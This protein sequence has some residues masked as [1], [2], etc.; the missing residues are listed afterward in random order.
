MDTFLGPSRFS[1]DPP[2]APGMEK[3]LARH[4]CQVVGL[5][6]NFTSKV[7]TPY[8]VQIEDRGPL[9]DAASEQWVR[10]VNVIVYA[11]YGEPNARIIHG[12]DHDFPDVRTQE[13]NRAASLLAYFITNQLPLED[14]EVLHNA[15]RLRTNAGN[16]FVPDVVVIP[17]GLAATQRGTRELESYAEPV[18]FVAETWSKS[19]GEYDTRTKLPEYQARGDLVIWLIHPYDRQVRVFER[20][21]DGSYAA[22]EYAGGRVVIPSLP[23]VA[24]DLDRLFSAL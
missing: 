10:R 22:R 13:H 23:G 7:G 15:G 20:Q 21:G 8:H 17:I 19:T 16:A 12:R 5:N 6:Q 11:N 14:F 1:T 9:L 4:L 3:G 24:V 2:E 18:P